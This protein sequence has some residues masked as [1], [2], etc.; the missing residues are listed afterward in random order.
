M[1]V[2]FSRAEF[3]FEFF[4]FLVAYDST[5]PTK[6]RDIFACSRRQKWQV[7][8]R[9]CNGIMRQVLRYTTVLRL[10]AVSIRRLSDR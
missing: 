9:D 10:V 5:I 8:L 4:V 3:S 6:V 2:R 1:T 7:S